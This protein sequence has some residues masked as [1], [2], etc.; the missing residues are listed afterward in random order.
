MDYDYS[1]YFPYE[2]DL[3]LMREGAKHF[4][5]THDFTSFC[6]AKTEKED[7][8]RTITAVEVDRTEDG[9]VFTLTG[10]G[11]LYNMVRIIVGTLLNVGS[12]RLAADKIPQLIAAKNRRHANK[13][14]PA[15][16]LYLWEVY[17]DN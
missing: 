17:Y 7:K 9:F 14:A 6:S 4:I 10:N 2:L 13:T 1:T 15:Q 3:S 8:V 11:F 12:N 16:G 5:G